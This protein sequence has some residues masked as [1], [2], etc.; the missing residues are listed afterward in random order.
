MR[1]IPVTI[2]ALAAAAAALAVGAVA[3]T[4]QMNATDSIKARQTHYKEI[5]ASFKTIRDELG[6]PSVDKAKVQAAS[7]K[8]TA[9]APQ[10]TGWFPKGSGSE[11]GLKTAARAEIWSD[12]KGFKEQSDNFIAQTQR[13][14][15][16]V[17]NG[18]VA[19]MKQ[20]V[21]TLG[22]AC[23]SCHDR[24]RVKTD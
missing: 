22:G 21:A 20:A 8:L 7:D 3:A 6:K 5:G 10:I 4:P 1:A 18:D 11:A 2:P 14:N 12:P 24:F 9:Y 13:F 19:Q 15:G 16:V 17:R 23:K